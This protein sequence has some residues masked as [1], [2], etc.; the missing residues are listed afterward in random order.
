[1]VRTR[2]SNFVF[3]LALDDFVFTDNEIRSESHSKVTAVAH[4]SHLLSLL[5]WEGRARVSSK[6]RVP[7]SH[8]GGG[9]R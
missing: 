1:M 5:K 3:S 4:R 9:R 7:A 8:A 2:T 6:N